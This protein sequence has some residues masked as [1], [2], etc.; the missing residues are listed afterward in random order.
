MT[1]SKE[2]H[3]PQP[4][5]ELDQVEDGYEGDLKRRWQQLQQLCATILKLSLSEMLLGQRAAGCDGV[6]GPEDLPPRDVFTF[7]GEQRQAVMAAM[8]NFVGEYATNNPESPLTWYYGQAH[9]LGLIQAARMVGKERPILDLIK[10]REIFE[11]LTNKGFQLVKDNATR[12]IVGKILPEMEAFAIAGANPVSVAAKLQQQ[13]GDQNSNWRRLARTELSM[14]AEDAK[15]KEWAAWEV[16]TVEFTP[17]P[18][19]CPACMALAG[20][21]PIAECPV[22]GRDTHP[23]CRCSSRP[24]KQEVLGDQQQ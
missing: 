1:G 13:F 16:E 22:A 19:G 9:S 21:Y 24:S 15:L 23:H 6:K 5:P 18:D 12:A 17:A 2:E 8:K 7:S 3:R 4:W 14:A 20:V 11:Q 10:N